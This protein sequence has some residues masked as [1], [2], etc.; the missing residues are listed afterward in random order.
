MSETGAPKATLKSGERVIIG[1]VLFGSDTTWCAISRE[2]E[3]KRF[4]YASCEFL[5]PA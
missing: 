5:E 2:G 3:T 4:G 1:M